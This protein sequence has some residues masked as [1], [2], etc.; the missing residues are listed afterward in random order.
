MK[1]TRLALLTALLSLGLATT[2][3][4]Q[5]TATQDVT[6]VVEQV[7]SIGVSA[8]SVTLTLNAA[9]PG[10]P[11]TDVT[12]NSTTYSLTTNGTAIKITGQ[13]DAAYAAGIALA[14]Q[15]AAPTEGGTS[16]QRTLS[17]TAQDLV[18]GIS[19]TNETGLSISYTASATSDAVPNAGGGGETHTVT[20]TITN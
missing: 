18:T 3:A 20:F 14:A 17:T 2:A 15:L 13:L 5:T 6:V 4:A 16:V 9:T 12:D 10:S 11:L 19:Y 8:S 7:S 1:T